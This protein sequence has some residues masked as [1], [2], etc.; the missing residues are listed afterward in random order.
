MAKKKIPVQAASVKKPVFRIFKFSSK[1]KFAI[2]CIVTLCFYANTFTNG[3]A[4]DDEAVIQR[5]DYVQKG[6][7]GIGKIFSTDAYDC[8]YRQNSSNQHLSGGR[9]RPLS[10]AL[11]AIEHQLWGES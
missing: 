9:Y 7:A 2:L 8:Y 1:I 3:Y 11:F 6:F 10:I 4:L 5:N